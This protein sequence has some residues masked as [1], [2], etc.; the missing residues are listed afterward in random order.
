MPGF[1]KKAHKPAGLLPFLPRR[2]TACHPLQ[3]PMAVLSVGF[4][5]LD[6]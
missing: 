2:I 1:V 3:V 5:G 6:K 4:F